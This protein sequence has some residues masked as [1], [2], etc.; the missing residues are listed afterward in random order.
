MSMKEGL[1]GVQDREGRAYCGTGGEDA[2]K[3]IAS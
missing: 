2:V 3:H 1:S